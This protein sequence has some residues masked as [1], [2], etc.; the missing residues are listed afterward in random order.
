MLYAKGSSQVSAAALRPSCH[1][2]SCQQSNGGEGRGSSR[3]RVQER[4]SRCVRI[5]DG[6]DKAGGF[7]GGEEGWQCIAGNVLGIPD[8]D[9]FQAKMHPS[10]GVTPTVQAKLPGW[11]MARE[12]WLLQLCEAENFA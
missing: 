12:Q 9:G 11:C 4:D 8:W 2:N 5:G 10:R 1:L 6:G 7:W 3:E